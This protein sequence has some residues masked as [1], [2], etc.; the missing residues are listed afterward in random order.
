M[1]LPGKKKESLGTPLLLRAYK[2]L[3]SSDGGSRVGDTRDLTERVRCGDGASHRLGCVSS[4]ESVGACRTENGVATTALPCVGVG[5]A[6]ASPSTS[7][8]GKELTDSCST[9]NGWCD[10]ADWSGS[11]VRAVIVPWNG[12]CICIF[13]PVL[14]EVI[15]QLWNGVED[16]TNFVSHGVSY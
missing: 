11:I 14:L 10:G 7:R 13:L 1:V 4:H 6:C 12:C 15:L 9:R 5:D 3:G 2:D 16:S 8:A